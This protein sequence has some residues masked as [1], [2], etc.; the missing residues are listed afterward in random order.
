MEKKDFI[1]Y[2]NKLLQE[3]SVEEKDA[4]ILTQAKL[5]EE[6]EAQDFIMALTGEKKISYM[7]TELQIEEFCRK[8]QNG[9]IFVEY[10]THYYE[11]DSEG[12]YMDDW[13]VRHN[14]PQGAFS[15]LNR[16]FHGCHDLICL[17]EYDLAAA[18]L[19]KICCLEFQVVEAEDSED[20]MDDS[21]FTLV[22]AGRESLLAMSPRE[23]GLDWITALLLGKENLE[24]AE[25][26]EKLI[27][28]MEL[29]MF[30][31]IQ[32]SDFRELLSEQLMGFMEETLEK[33]LGEISEK[34]EKFS[35]KHW[36]EKYALEKKRARIQHLL[37]DI[38]KNAEAGRQ[39]LKNPVRYQFWRIHG[40]R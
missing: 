17:G 4:W 5:T 7:P 22:D 12:R 14:D 8:V 27:G 19:N 35:D 34:L 10:E 2:I 24:N 21:R 20:F 28:I 25:F 13:E 6:S 39:K 11:F 1:N 9:D 3:M 30:E 37:L 23:I 16:T 33:A 18:I 29:E 38:R 26:A 36:R 40:S 31:K 32:P 15:F